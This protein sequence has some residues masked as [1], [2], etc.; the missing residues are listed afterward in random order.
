[1][2]QSDSHTSFRLGLLTF[3]SISMVGV[4]DLLTNL[5][6][7]A[8]YALIN[9]KWDYE[10]GLVRRGLPGEILSI[11]G[12]PHSLSNVLRLSILIYLSGVFVY[13]IY[14]TVIAYHRPRTSTFFL[15]LLGALLSPCLLSYS[16]TL[17]RI[18]HFNLSILLISFLLLCFS[19]HIITCF[20]ISALGG[21]AAL[22][23]ESFILVDL[24][25]ILAMLL[26]RQT[27]K[28]Y[29]DQRLRL[30]IRIPLVFLG[31]FLSIVAVIVN[32]TPKMS[33]EDWVRY[34][35]SHEPITPQVT[36][37]SILASEIHYRSVVGNVRYVLDYL[38]IHRLAFFYGTYLTVVVVFLGYTLFTRILASSNSK[39]LGWVLFLSSFSPLGMY[40]LGVDFM[41]WASYSLFHL[42]IAALAFIYHH[43]P[44]TDL[45]PKITLRSTLVFLCLVSLLS[46]LFGGGQWFRFSPYSK[47][48]NLI[49]SPRPL[50]ENCLLQ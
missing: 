38:S 14:A 39:S 41:R 7:P 49:V 33:I 24:P 1:M 50:P 3:V 42:I 30:V 37:D 22:I 10:L 27:D 19:D 2:S 36:E 5:K 25:L 35:S 12:I 43:D 46:P 34:W 32:G 29:S 23:H 17:G 48:L 26:I 31:P 6:P 20:I 4:L 47:C 18:D 15:G 28:V 40:F 44:L 8:E 13:S 45:P 16:L 11:L 21:A 9:W